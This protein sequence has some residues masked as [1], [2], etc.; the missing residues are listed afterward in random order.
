MS[1]AFDCFR[2]DIVAAKA[3]EIKAAGYTSVGLYYFMSSA[4]KVM[5]TRELAEKISAAALYIFSVWENGFPTAGDYFTAAQG[6]SDGKRAALCG[7]SVGQP[8]ETPIYFAVDYDAAES[9]LPG[10]TAYFEALRPRL[11]ADGYTA[12]V[13]GSGLVCRHLSELG[14]V[15]KTW[16][17]ESTGFA[18]HADWLP[19]ADIV[20]GHST[21]L[22]GMDI[23]TDTTNGS[24]G[25]FQ[26]SA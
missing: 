13:Y 25:G 10:I 11:Q 18:G 24:A 23:D 15:S 21:Q 8:A 17:S 4:F 2:P 6:A 22:F 19:H 1:K 16:L 5:L 14:L 9:D 20:Q 26:V 3:Q 12:G 7:L